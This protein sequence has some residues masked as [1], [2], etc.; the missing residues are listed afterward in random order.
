MSGSNEKLLFFVNAMFCEA[1]VTKAFQAGSF[2]E[3]EEGR[4]LEK[5]RLS[6]LVSC[7]PF[8]RTDRALCRA[9]I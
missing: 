3:K 4:E 9:D 7:E 2:C 6:V 1:A 8:R 5:R